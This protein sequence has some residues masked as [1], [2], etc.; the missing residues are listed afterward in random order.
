[1]YD[2]NKL[3]LKFTLIMILVSVFNYNNL[4]S[5]S[6]PLPTRQASIEA[7]ERGNYQDAYNNFSQLL[8]KYPKDP[9]YRYYS[10]A[11]LV[12][13]K[14]DADEAVS[15]LQQSLN[16][17][18]VVRSLPPDALF[19]LGRAQQMSGK[20][21][22]AIASFSSYTDQV[23]KKKAREQGVPGYIQECENRKGMVSPANPVVTVSGSKSEV[24]KPPEKPDNGGTGT[25]PAGKENS[26]RKE[27]PPEYENILDEALKLQHKADSLNLITGEQKSR[28]ELVPDAEKSSLKMNISKNEILAASYQKSADLKY[29]E[30]QAKMNPAHEKVSQKTDSLQLSVRTESVRASEVAII[31]SS[32]SQKDTLKK[33]VHV[34]GKP[35][36]YYSYFDLLPKGAAYPD[37]KIKIDPKVP[38]GLIYRI[39]LAVFRNPVAPSFFKGIT[40]VYGFKIPSS[41]KTIYYAGIFRRS[42][43]AK[44]ALQQVKETGF[45]DAFIVALS[46]KKPVS[47]DRA[48]VLE[49]EWGMK[50]FIDLTLPGASLDTIPPTLSFRVEVVRALKPL[51]TDAVEAL[52]ATAGNRG[53]DILHLT[54]GNNVYLIGKFITFESAAEYADLLIRNNYR[55]AKVVAWLGN[56]EVP[57]ETAKQLF[58]DLK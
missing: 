54:D 51:K 38:D 55:G 39:Q 22:E 16:G 44:K 35:A 43:D 15:L 18:S 12:M 1:M 49:K 50:P 28:L 25:K 29:N 34:P 30:A 19:Y 58:N 11:S 26:G 52:R 7:F 13:M 21:T 36:V 14:K 10:G 53:L 6:Q 8:L 32:A 2:L 31:S 57:V 3:Q 17:A 33:Q 4:Y 37:E 41:D 46:D 27:L 5:Q 48:A 40:P 9:L 45:R 56:K 24:S 20:F 42:A 47:T 23:G